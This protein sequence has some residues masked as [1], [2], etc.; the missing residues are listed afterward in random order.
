LALVGL[1]LAIAT[2]FAWRG[3]GTRATGA[4]RARMERSP[5]WSAAAGHF[6]NPEPL[7]N[8]ILESIRDGFAAS[9]FVRLAP[10]VPSSC[11]PAVSRDAAPRN[12]AGGRERTGPLARPTDVARLQETPPTGLRVTWLGHAATLL[13]IDGIRV[14]IDPQRSP[15]AS[16]IAGENAPGAARWYPP[17]LPIGDLAALHPDAVVISH[18]HYDHLDR[19]AIELLATTTQVRFF[20]PLGVGADLAYWGVPEGR[21][22]ELDWWETA[23]VG[24][25]TLHALPARHASGRGILDKDGNLW[26]GWGFVGPRHRVYFSGDTGLFP[27]MKTIG[28][29]LG[30]FDLTMI[31]VG[32]YDRAWPDWHI[33]PEQAVLAHQLVRGKVFLPIHWGLYALAY[34]GWTE[35]AER[36]RAEALARNEALLLPRPGTTVDVGAPPQP[37]PPPERWWP[38]VP[39]KTGAEDPIVSTGC[40][41]VRR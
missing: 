31:E 1:A 12:F 17:P 3:L 14:L 37:L 35:P 25:V 32:Q 36:A 11:G 10:E 2:P 6:V 29:R 7:D 16:P 5:Q 30:P 9:P 20:V 8:H 34:H 23:T 24:P 41:A 22:T 39:W 38:D 13:E 21:I 4:R 19:G 26:A 33:G 18:D 28:E 15:K 40:E 27:A